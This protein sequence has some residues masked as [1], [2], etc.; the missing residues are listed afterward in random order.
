MRVDDGGQ[1]REDLARAQSVG[2][3]SGL[4][5]AVVASLIVCIGGGILVDQYFGTAPVFTLVGVAL[6]LAAAGYQLYEL[7]LIGR[8]DRGSGP[9]GRTIARGVVARK[10]QRPVDDQDSGNQTQ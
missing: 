7:T 10:R 9:V 1:S 6:G 8:K 4:G 3:A 2:V 5:C